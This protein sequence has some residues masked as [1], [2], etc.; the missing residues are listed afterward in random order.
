LA[1]TLIRR[2]EPRVSPE[3]RGST[4]PRHGLKC[5]SLARHYERKPSAASKA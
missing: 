5:T 4:M 1:S 2:G 3:G